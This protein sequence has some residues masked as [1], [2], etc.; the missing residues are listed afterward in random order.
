MHKKNQLLFSLPGGGA[1]KEGTH[2]SHIPKEVFLT[3]GYRVEW[4]ERLFIPLV[5]AGALGSVEY[6]IL[7]TRKKKAPG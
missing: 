7:E 4:V 2:S 3:P 6:N 5:E 1:W